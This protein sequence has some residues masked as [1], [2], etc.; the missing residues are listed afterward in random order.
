MTTRRNLQFLLGCLI[1]HSSIKYTLFANLSN[2]I[3]LS[4]FF[5]F[6]EMIRGVF[7]RTLD[8]GS[9][10]TASEHF[11]NDFPISTDSETF[12]NSFSIDSETSLNQSKFQNLYPLNSSESE[13]N[14]ECFYEL[15]L[16]QIE[17]Q[18]LSQHCRYTKK[19]HI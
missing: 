12:Q 11:Q 15:A 17:K 8:S 14:S 1:F 7:Y 16:N 6:I 5:A 2:A 19:L 4:E 9:N 3:L 13:Q 18:K 10:R